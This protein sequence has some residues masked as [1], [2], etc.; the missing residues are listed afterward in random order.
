MSDKLIQKLKDCNVRISK[1]GNICLNDFV[2][3]VIKSK[4]PDQYMK[5]VPDKKTINDEYYINPDN[6]I[7]ILKQGKSK[8]CKDIVEYIEKDEDDKESIV[9]PKSNKFQFEGH[10][11]LA[12]F[13]DDEE[14]EDNWQVWIRASQ[15]A[16]F[17]GYSNPSEAINDNVEQNNIIKF[18]NLNELLS[19]SQKL[20]LKS[21]DKKTNFIN[22]SGFFNL[23]HK[24]NKNVAKRIKSFIDND[25]LP[26]IIKTGCYNMQPDKI[27][28]KFF[29]D[30]AA[31]SD[32][33]NLA[34]MYIAYI[35]KHKNLHLFKYGLTRDIFSRDF[36]QHRKSFDQF[37]IIFIQQCDNCEKVE[38]LFENEL[39][40]RNLHR[41]MTINGKAQTELFTISTKFTHDYF[42]DL[43]KK[44]INEHKL[45]AIKEADNKI[46][47]LNNVLDVHNNSNELR[48]MEYDLKKM[49]YD[50][51]V[52]ENYRLELQRDIKM[53][54]RDIKVKEIDS[55]TAIAIENIK[56]DIEREKSKQIA[57][58]KGYDLNLFISNVTKNVSMKTSKKNNNVLKI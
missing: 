32:F 28:I 23:I 15:V 48:K 30:D 39:I 4:N 11:F 2:E 27:K 36:K 42:I 34:C 38:S 10:R 47:T 33:A 56:L 51:R 3:N 54:E 41:N 6:T 21:I 40:V 20:G 58:E 29:Y 46:I 55:E 9:D 13:I 22:L 52:T 44:I 53:K 35:G 24:S 16:D 25:V 17:L 18:E 57:M 37:T 19:S 1:K 45:P 31:L 12:F 50:Y 14:N 26:A 7:E 49:K 8:L 5:R 43:M